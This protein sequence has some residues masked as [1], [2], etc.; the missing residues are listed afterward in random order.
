MSLSFDVSINKPIC[1]CDGA[2]TVIASGGNPPYQYSIDGGITY[3]NFPVFSNLC[4][5]NYYTTVLDISGQ[6]VSRYTPLFSP[7]GKTTYTMTLNTTSNILSITNTTNIVQY[8]TTLNITPEL[9]NSTYVTFDIIKTSSINSSPTFSSATKS[10]SS[11]LTYNSS[12]I[13]ISYSGQVTGETYN[14]IPGCQNY[15][16]Y[17]SATTEVW[18]NLTYYN[19]DEFTLTTTDTNYKNDETICYIGESNEKFSLSNLKIHGCGCCNIIQ[20]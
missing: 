6:T 20:T 11:V 10:S 19:G 7:S 8:N 13:T 18:T 1:G 3:K 16:L 5:A 14:T 4:G 15:T 9:P 17:T 12:A 2:I